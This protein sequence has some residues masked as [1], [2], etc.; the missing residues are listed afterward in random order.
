MPI[1]FTVSGADGRP[2]EYTGHFPDEVAEI[3][4]R[5]ERSGEQLVVFCRDAQR[6]RSL[7]QVLLAAEVSS[8]ILTP[9]ADGS[10]F[11]SLLD[12]FS[13]NDFT[14][15]LA[16]DSHNCGWMA[17]STCRRVVHLDLPSANYASQMIDALADRE[18][19]IPRTLVADVMERAAG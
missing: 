15:L 13:H 9:E 10:T 11:R 14:A 3:A 18:A 19:R 6:A 2:R 16:T 12:A 8:A 17:P 1:R 5:A 7:G 4:A